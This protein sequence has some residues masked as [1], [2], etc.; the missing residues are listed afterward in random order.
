M[1]GYSAIVGV[2]WQ[3]C[4]FLPDRAYPRF[5]EVQTART[6]NRRC[7]VQWGRGSSQSLNASRNCEPTENLGF[8]PKEQRLMN[9]D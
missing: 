7:R 8:S 6:R 3:K 1:R 2:Y 5:K 9:A 4:G